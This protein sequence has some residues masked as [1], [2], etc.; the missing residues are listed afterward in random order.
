MRSFIFTVVAAITVFCGLWHV[1]GPHIGYIFLPFGIIVGIALSA[2]VGLATLAGLI[3]LFVLWR[4]NAHAKKLERSGYHV[5]LNRNTIEQFSLTTLIAITMGS[6]L[7][8]F[9]ALMYQNHGSDWYQ[10]VLLI[11]VPWAIVFVFSFMCSLHVWRKSFKPLGQY[12][13]ALTNG[14]KIDLPLLSK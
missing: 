6:C 3:F 9:C 12:A 10:D 13:K 14:Q 5:A 1:A 4:A 2:I 7:S 8:I 11:I